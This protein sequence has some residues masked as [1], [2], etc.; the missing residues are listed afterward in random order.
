MDNFISVSCLIAE[1]DEEAL[2]AVVE[3]RRT[4]GAWLEP[5]PNGLLR[6]IIYLDASVSSQTSALE[7]DLEGIGA[8][9]VARQLVPSRDWLEAYRSSARPF[10][11]GERWWV[12]PRPDD[13][14][15]F[16]E[17][18]VC[19]RVEPSTAFGSG[20]HESTKLVLTALEELPIADARVLDLGAGS[21]IL[22]LA[23]DALGARFTLGVDVDPLAVWVARRVRRQQAWETRLV[24]AVG[25]VAALAD[26]AFDIVLCNMLTAGLHPL[27]PS[28]RDRL[29]AGGRAVLSGMQECELGMMREAV[30]GCRLRVCRERILGE[31]AALEVERG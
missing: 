24:L 16:P 14:G 10:S 22:G 25:T 15:P 11:V 23:A 19:L 31:W 7:A 30:G 5:V 17:N 27:L 3:E 13:G 8:Q 9:E 6:A 2:A 18:R 26:Q 20:S 28:I 1:S 4:L 21:G 29:V 12:E